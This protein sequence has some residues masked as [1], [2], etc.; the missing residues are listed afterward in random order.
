MLANAAQ[1]VLWTVAP[2]PPGQK[3]VVHA[4][5]EAFLSEQVLL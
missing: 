4:N 5:A 3:D 1:P 2:P